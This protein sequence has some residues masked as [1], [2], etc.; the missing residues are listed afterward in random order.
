[1]DPTAWI[2]SADRPISAVD[3]GSVA[4]PTA[5]VA[6]QRWSPNPVRPP[7][8]RL[9]HRASRPTIPSHHHLQK[10]EAWEMS[11]QDQVELMSS[12]TKIR[13]E[14]EYKTCNKSPM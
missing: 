6:C 11:K 7:S 3:H 5:L 13:V 14:I 10:I 8:T 1:M 2:R 12:T 4:H 9:L